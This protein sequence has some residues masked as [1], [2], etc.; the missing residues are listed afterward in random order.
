M[1]APVR[2]TFTSSGSVEQVLAVL[3]S[4]DWSAVKA[5]R[6]GDGAELR[7]RE[8]RPDGGVRVVNSRQL[9][10]GAP[11]FLQRFLPADGRVLETFDWGPPEDGAR[12]GTWQVE[13]PGAP[14]TLGGTTSLVPTASGSVYTI[15]GEVTVKV[16]LIGGKAESFIAGMV[17]KLAAKE[18]ELVVAQVE[19]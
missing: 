4:P 18:A 7:A 16:P 5:E 12:Y 19:A 15:E 1:S 10:D 3:T 11:G 13:I 17:E 8:V 6:F 14:A 9:P 2:S